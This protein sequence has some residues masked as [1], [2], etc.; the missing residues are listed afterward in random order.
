MTADLRALTKEKRELDMKNTFIVARRNSAELAARTKAFGVIPSRMIWRI[1]ACCFIFLS[2]QLSHAVCNTLTGG[3]GVGATD[4]ITVLMLAT[5]LKGGTDTPTDLCTSL[6]VVQA[7]ALGLNV[8]IDDATAWGAK[9][10]ANF[11]TYRAIVL[12]DPDCVATNVPIT[13]AESTTGTW[14]PA[15]TGPIA[16]IGTDPEFH[17]LN[18]SGAQAAQLTENAIAFATSTSGQPGAYISLSCYYVNSPANTSVPVLAPF[19]SFTVQGTSNANNSNI[20]APTNALVNTPNALNNVGLSNWSESTHEAF[21]SFPST[22]TAVV[23]SVDFNL[24]YILTNPQ[25]QQVSTGGTTTF[26]F[27]GGLNAGGYDYTAKL[28]S[29]SSVNVQVKPIVIADQGTC[30]SIVQANPIF[31]GTQ[32]FMYQK[33]D[34]TNTKP[35]MFEVTCPQSPGGTCGTDTLRNF[36]AELGT[37]FNFLVPDNPGFDGNNPSAGWLKGAGPD[38]LNPCTLPTTGA[39]FKSN[40]I[41]SFFVDADP[42]HAK[43]GSGGT[44]SCWLL[45]YNTPG[46]APSVKIVAPANGGIYPQGASIPA[47]F[48]CSAVNAGANSP[49]G[50]YLTVQ[51][52]TGT[53]PSGT[54]FDTSTVGPHNF[55]ATVVDSANNTALQTVTYNVVAPAALNIVKLAPSRI[56]VNS[57]LIY[58]IL[59]TDN[60]PNPNP[61]SAVGVVV[62]DPLPPNTT[63]VSASGINNACS[64][65]NKKLSCS[66]K[67]VPCSLGA[68]N[69]VTCT[70]GT[71]APAAVWFLNGVAIQITVGVKNVGVGNSITNVAMV[72]EFNSNNH[73]SNPATTKVTT[74]EK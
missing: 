47:S 38:P 6:E 63:F 15:I 64:F 27:Q 10:T 28:N 34:G 39:L 43:G 23:Q 52:C 32:C 61:V 14:G 29:G 49:I 8:E 12:G 20:V 18:N 48:S 45:T 62:S 44:G 68:G 59:V 36:D 16:L 22:F 70:V 2:S 35:V 31:Q 46:E 72:S 33:A 4:N 60:S 50:P 21:N 26:N 57:K 11:A 51:T 54:P 25:T 66:I 65:I 5:T 40:Q 58:G 53:V 30:N 42:A 17:F 73:S 19:G 55:T 37:D 9:S 7:N 3:S 41:D 69:T 71:V 13:E 1:L 67:A 74:P 24:P 56:S